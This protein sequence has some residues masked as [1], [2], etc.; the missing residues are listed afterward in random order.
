M[1]DTSRPALKVVAAV[2]RRN[3]G[4]ILIARRPTHLDQGGLWEFPGGKREPGEARLA[5]LARELDEELGIDVRRGTPL[6]SLEHPY[7]DK[8]VHLDIWEIAQWRGE[9]SGR[10][11]QTIRWIAA[12][13]LGNFKFPAANTTIITAAH[14]PRLLI[15]LSAAFV[16]RGNFI[17]T[18]EGYLRSGFT[19]F[20]LPAC[21]PPTREACA[22]LAKEYEATIHLADPA[23]GAALP[24]GLGLHLNAADL[25]RAVECIQ[26]AP[27]PSGLSASVATMEDFYRAREIGADWIVLSGAQG[28]LLRDLSSDLRSTVEAE[29]VPTYKSATFDSDEYADALRDGFQGPVVTDPG[30]EM[31]PEA[32]AETFRRSLARASVVL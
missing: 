14:L 26:E 5:A 12:R 15:M 32:L 19:A 16:A 25:S 9:P 8:D 31:T 3:D 17:Q 6:L 28:K 20:V 7:P 1:S 30:S 18:L 24:D 2:I 4:R 21:A 11:A 29:K 13:E 23:G 22:V 27:A 10:E